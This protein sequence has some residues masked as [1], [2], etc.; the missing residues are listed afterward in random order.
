MVRHAS[1]LVI[2]TGGTPTVS[3]FIGK[4]RTDLF[5]AGQRA[6]E[7]PRWL[8]GDIARA[9][10]RANDKYSSVAPYLK[11]ELLLTIRGSR[12]YPSPADCWWIDSVEYP[13]GQWPKWYQ[14]FRESLSPYVPE[15]AEG[16]G[17]V[18]PDVGTA[19]T[20]MHTW[21]VTFVGV[22]GTTTL[23]VPIATLTAPQGE[24]YSAMVTGIPVGPYG[25]VDRG[26]YR[27]VGTEPAQLVGTIGDNSTEEYL[28]AVPESGLSGAAPVAN[29]TQGVAQFE[30]QISNARLPAVYSDHVGVRYATK[31]ELDANGC[32]IPERHWDMLCL[33]GAMYAIMAYLVPQADNFEYVDGQFRDR[34]DDTKAP[35]AWLNL[36]KEME[37][38]FEER[39]AQVRQEANA[40]VTAI[41]SWGD[42][43]LRWDRL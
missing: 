30:I 7:Q 26:I 2:P 4:I 27:S 1:P 28:D 21:Y 43:P 5:G 17:S 15:P 40:G 31:H 19:M 10:D 34:V 6:G 11:Q 18:T 9:L 29:T 37:R 35:A 22:G 8:D 3:E 36:G 12:I 16:G 32:S 25:I 33:G 24:T 39:L 23:P 38:R 14:T 41:G 13:Y 20:G 42:K